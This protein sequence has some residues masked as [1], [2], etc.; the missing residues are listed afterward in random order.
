MDH[1]LGN[2]VQKKFT[3]S[4]VQVWVIT[5]WSANMCWLKR[6]ATRVYGNRLKHWSATVVIFLYLK[7]LNSTCYLVK[8][9]KNTIQ[10]LPQMQEIRQLI[11][12]QIFLWAVRQQQ[13][14]TIAAPKLPTAQSRTQARKCTHAAFLILEVRTPIA[15]AIWGTTWNYKKYK[16]RDM[17]K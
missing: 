11:Y 8:H 7:Y 13:A 9:T 5:L 17:H 3:A 14:H 6:W 16:S 10:V 1:H 2:L 15:H 12:S 4:A